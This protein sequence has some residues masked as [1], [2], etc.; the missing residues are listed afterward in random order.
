MAGA[1]V[2]LVEAGV[3]S[4]PLQGRTSKDGKVTLGP[5]APGP[6]T[7][8]A[9]ATDFVGGPLV[10]VP[11]VVTEPVRV[12]LIRGGRL[13]GE[14]VDDRGFPIE[15]AGIEIVGTD[16]FGLPIAETPLVNRFRA[17]H[18]EWSLGGPPRSS[19]QVSSG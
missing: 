8:S 16:R 6:A 9:R 1:D 13:R 11:D 3:A 2:V 12:P 5:I 14:V 15:G 18:F 19:P 17:V 4:F 7:L 10:V